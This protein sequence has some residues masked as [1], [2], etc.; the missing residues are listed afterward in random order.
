MYMAASSAQQLNTAVLRDETESIADKIAARGISS[1]DMQQ[2]FSFIVSHKV[3]ISSTTPPTKTSLPSTPVIPPLLTRVETP[4]SRRLLISE[5]TVEPFLYSYVVPSLC[6]G[7]GNVDNHCATLTS[8]TRLPSSSPRYPEGEAR[9]FIQGAYIGTTTFHEASPNSF[10]ELSLGS[11]HQLHIS[12][13]FIPPKGKGVEEDKSTWFVSDKKSF[14]AITY[15]WQVTVRSEHPHPVLV[16]LSESLPISSEESI[17][18]ELESP[19]LQT[20]E[21]NPPQG[22]SGDFKRD[23]A[24]LLADAGPAPQSNQREKTKLKVYLNTA[25]QTMYWVG[26]KTP[27]D[28]TESFVYKY[29]IAFEDG[30]TV[31]IDEY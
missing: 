17:K 14:R 5:S 20:L 13:V 23:L 6:R 21:K 25:T 15:E 9:L 8:L 28:P 7:S 1:G 22:W 11:D 27:S 18:V 26:W 4:G 29:K 16:V 30:K 2:S 12:T 31:R 10:F 19:K 24:W 3:N